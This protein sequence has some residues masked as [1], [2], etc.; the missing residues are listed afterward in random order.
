[1]KGS[2]R[3]FKARNFYVRYISES[4]STQ[5]DRK[6]LAKFPEGDIILF[7]TTD[8]SISEGC[9]Y[10]VQK[11]RLDSL[12]LGHPVLRMFSVEEVVE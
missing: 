3:I 8:S 9:W 12:P 2:A 6:G 10:R 1:M 7:Q 4:K 5:V 11:A